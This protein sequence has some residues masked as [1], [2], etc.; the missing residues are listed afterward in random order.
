MAQASFR[1]LAPEVL[2]VA[3]ACPVPTIVRTAR[4][5]CR[6][7]AM[8]ALCFRFTFRD[9]PVLAG[10]SSVTLPLPPDTVLANIE[11]LN[12]DGERLAPT[13]P[14]LMDVDRQNWRSEDGKPYRYMRDHNC[15]DGVILYPRPADS[16]TLA[17]EVSIAPS[18]TATGIE[19]T[20]MDR[21][22]TQIVDGT[23]AM[24]LAVPSA[25]WFNPTVAA[26]HRAQFERG[27]DEGRRIADMDDLPKRRSVKYGGM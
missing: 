19:E 5:A 2:S 20:Y 3:A 6:E 16:A 11:L 18:R 22:F 21:F 17:G 26:Y 27:L 15:I 9:H 4:N 14:A 10:E 13:S 12:L 25:P 23:L 1:D 7:L 8:R 24:L